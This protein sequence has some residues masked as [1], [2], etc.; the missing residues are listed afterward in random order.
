MDAFNPTL[1]ARLVSPLGDH[2]RYR[3][4]L[5]AQ[6]TRELGRIAAHPGL[7]KNVAELAAKALGA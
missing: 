4:G 6:M 1:A 5:A 3:Q 7:S 2:A